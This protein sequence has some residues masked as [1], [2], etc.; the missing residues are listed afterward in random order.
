MIA[1]SSLLNW[2]ISR[3]PFS[4]NVREESWFSFV[5]TELNTQWPR[6]AGAHWLSVR[7]D[8]VAAEDPQSSAITLPYWGDFAWIQRRYRQSQEHR[9]SGP[10]GPQ[11]TFPHSR[12]CNFSGKT[13]DLEKAQF[14]N[15]LC[16]WTFLFTQKAFIEH[17]EELMLLNC[18]VGE[19]SW[20][21]LGLQG[22]PISSS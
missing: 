22:D 6:L 16:S 9:W 5:I 19:D 21:S 14:K 8:L 12:S 18:G 15:H 10:A 1:A 2:S 11:H 4:S 13:W 20:E 3:N 7:W 17:Q